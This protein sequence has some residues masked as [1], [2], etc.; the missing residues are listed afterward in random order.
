MTSAAAVRSALRD[1][2]SVTAQTETP[3]A[4]AAPAFASIICGVDGSRPSYE[5][6]RQAGV[7]AGDTAA[8]TYVAVTWEQGQG[9]T[10]VATLS[11]ARGDNALKFDTRG[12]ARRTTSPGA[13][14]PPATTP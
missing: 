7:L 14:C 2:L 5:A 1:D 6:A 9:A 11:H 8:L 12:S 4:S 10:A 13:A 3:P